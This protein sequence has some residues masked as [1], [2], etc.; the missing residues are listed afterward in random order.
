MK[1]IT[2][3]GQEFMYNICMRLTD[4]DTYYWTEFFKEF[5]IIYKKR[6]IFFGK[7]IKKE[8]PKILFKVNF[9]IEDHTETTE[10]RIMQKLEKEVELLN[11]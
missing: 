10:K 1:K 5:D 8:I 7:L 4:I 2:I 3:S 6:F 11:K 9:D